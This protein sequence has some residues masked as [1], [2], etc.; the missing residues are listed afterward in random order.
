MDSLGSDV[1]ESDPGSIFWFNLI[2]AIKDSYAVERMSEQLLHQLATEQVGDIEAYWV[3]WL[4]FL[5][6]FSNAK[7]QRD[8]CLLTSF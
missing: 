6:G 7:Y 8:P 1:L 2:Q 3:L 4:L 5:P